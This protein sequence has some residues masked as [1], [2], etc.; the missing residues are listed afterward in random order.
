[1]R[2]GLL[3][4]HNPDRFVCERAHKMTG[5][6][7]RRAAEHRSQGSLLWSA[8]PAPDSHLIRRSGQALH[9]SP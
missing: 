5:N 7:L 9:T 4:L 2:G 8:G 3:H 1:M 6:E